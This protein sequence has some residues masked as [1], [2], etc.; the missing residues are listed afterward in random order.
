MEESLSCNLTTASQRELQLL[1]NRRILSSI[2]ENVSLRERARL[3]T[4]ASPHS[5]DWLQAILNPRRGLSMLPY[6]FVLAT[7]IWL[8]IPIFPFRQYLVHNIDADADVD[9]GIEMDPIPASA[10]ASTS[11]DAA[12]VKAVSLLTLS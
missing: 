4:V 6:E 2:K 1:V 8:G 11:K 7:R 9:A 12:C 5:G 3:N 10:L